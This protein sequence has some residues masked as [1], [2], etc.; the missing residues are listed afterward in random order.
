MK[1]K[2]NGKSLELK[3]NLGALN[4][5][6]NSG[7]GLHD[8]TVPGRQVRAQV[9]MVKACL[10]PQADQQDVADRIESN[11]M[12]LDEAIGA[13]L[14]KYGIVP[15][16]EEDDEQESPEG[17]APGAGESFAPSQKSNSGSTRKSLKPA[18]S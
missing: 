11:L 14:V 5:F 7:F 9:E 1:I 17:N 16:G 6:E 8:F 18:Q 2:Y 10:D 4:R 12:Q 3:I 15:A 13:A